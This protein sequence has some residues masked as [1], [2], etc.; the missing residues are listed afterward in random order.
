V[1]TKNRPDFGVRA[2]G[3]VHCFR[4]KR[5]YQPWRRLWHWL[6]PKFR[7][8]VFPEQIAFSN[9]TS[10]HLNGPVSGLIHNGP[11]GRPRNGRA[12]RMSLPKRM[13]GITW[14]RPT[15]PAP[16]VSS[17]LGPRRFPTIYPAEPSRAERERKT[18]AELAAKVAET[19][20]WRPLRKY[21]LTN[22]QQK[23][24]L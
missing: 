19:W 16:Q 8:A 17:P 9:I 23:Q 24:Q 13:P 6:Q 5:V 7:R 21:G 3:F 15:R 18:R 14:P 4:W 1:R 11:L 10:Y 22:D 2:S 20:T 12:R